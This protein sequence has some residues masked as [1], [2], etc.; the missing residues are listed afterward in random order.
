[1]QAADLDA[2]LALAASLQ[3]APHWP[4]S[5]YQDAMNPT[6]VVQRIALVAEARGELLGFA[7]ASLLV[8]EA[9]LESIAVAGSAQRRGVGRIL[10]AELRRKIEQFGVL[11]LRLE[12]SRPLLSIRLRAGRRVAFVHAITL[13][14]WRMHCCSNSISKSHFFPKAESSGDFHHVCLWRVNIFYS[15]RVLWLFFALAR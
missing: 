13:I 10:L 5:A 3:T 4:R 14:L 1:M 8:P 7:V 2:V 6:A 12:I 9:E 15:F 11:E